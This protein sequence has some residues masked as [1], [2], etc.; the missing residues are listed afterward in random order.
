MGYWDR[1]IKKQDALFNASLEQTQAQYRKAY[2]QALQATQRDI[3][4][5][6]DKLQREA[7]DGKIK[8]NDIYR[9]NRYFE[10]QSSL[11]QRLL[12]LGGKE[13]KITSQNLLDLYS[14]TSK[15]VGE[16]IEGMGR[17]FLLENGE[18]AKVAVESVWCADGKHWSN[19]I[20]K[21]KS[22][23]Q[24]RIETGLVDCLARGVGKDELV[25]Q[26]KRDF[27]VSFSN[28]DRLAR[29]ELSY[30]QNRAAADRYKANGIEKYEYLASIDDRTSEQCKNLN[31][32]IFSFSD[33]VVGV[34]FPPSHPR[35]RCTIVPVIEGG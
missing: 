34:N 23:L 21:Q 5:L 8:M 33:M 19:R 14:L 35:C 18:G 15:M 9:Y 31:G 30:I 4:D 13:Q 29:T 28:A 32:K 16:D 7:A 6:Y 3:E 10:L 24:T 17:S 27:S 22:L 12:A 26:L 20:W 11:N 2:L 25:K 1:R